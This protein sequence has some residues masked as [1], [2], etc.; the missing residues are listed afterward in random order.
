MSNTK[1]ELLTQLHDR[2]GFDCE[3]EALNLYIKKSAFQ[4]Q[5]RNTAKTHVLTFKGNNVPILAFITLNVCEIDVS[6]DKNHLY[7]KSL[8][9]T[10]P[11]LRLCRLAVDKRYQKLGLSHHLM[12]FTLA[13]ALE[14]SQSVGCAGIV[15]DAKDN[16]A[17]EYYKKFGFQTLSSKPLTLFISMKTIVKLVSHDSA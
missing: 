8:P 13:K 1:V 16:S 10:I 15:V 2:E 7:F 6:L 9:N 3:T 14:L 11:A 5:K 17:K 4:Q 12:G